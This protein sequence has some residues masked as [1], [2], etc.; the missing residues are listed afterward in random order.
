MTT[1]RAAAIQTGPQGEDRAANLAAASALIRSIEPR[2]DVVVLPEL[3]SL[4]FWCVGVHDPAY[5]DWAEPVDGPTVTAMS[6]VARSIGSYVVAPF[7]E[8]GEREGEYFNSAALI[9]PDGN[10]VP[11]TLD[12]GR[13]VATYRKNAISSYAWDGHINNEK[14]YFRPGDGYPVFATAFGR[15]GILICYDRW[16]PEAWRV[17]ALQGAR[18]VFVVN[19]SEGYVSDMF[20]PSMRTSAA[21]NVLFAVSVNRGGVER[22]GDVETRYYGRSCIVG[23]RGDVLAEAGEGA[24]DVVIAADLDLSRVAADRKRL[25]VFRDRRPELYGAIT[26]PDRTSN[27]GA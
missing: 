19:A 17:L 27:H 15:V 22:F 1:L 24:P 23:P 11:G 2:P 13:S 3:F 18:A 25:W 6:E 8:R 20:V 26:D 9:G 5:F 4:P 7:F 12:D 14:W 10:L 16:Y 21:Q